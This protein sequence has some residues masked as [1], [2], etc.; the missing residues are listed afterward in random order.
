MFRNCPKNLKIVDSRRPIMC[1]GRNASRQ[2]CFLA[3]ITCRRTAPHDHITVQTC[4]VHRFMIL[5]NFLTLQRIPN[6]ENVCS[7]SLLSR[8]LK[9]SSIKKLFLQIDF[10][11][12]HRLLDKMHVSC[13]ERYWWCKKLIW[14]TFA[15]TVINA[16]SLTQS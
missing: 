15:A 5:R 11:F 6:K 14:W 1:I 9:L 4:K 16:E 12:Q 10:L 7:G 2:K 8:V 13:H 3:E